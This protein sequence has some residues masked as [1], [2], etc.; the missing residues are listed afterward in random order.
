M[1]NSREKIKNILLTTILTVLLFACLCGCS[2]STGGLLNTDSD[3]ILPESGSA[4]IYCTDTANSGIFHEVYSFISESDEQRLV[5]LINMLDKSPETTAYKKAKPSE[6][7]IEFY[8]IGQDG[9]LII[10]FSP[11]YYNMDSL[12]EI[13][14]RAAVVKTL[15]QLE[16]YTYIEFYVGGQPIQI[17]GVP[18]GM[19]TVDDFVDKT[20]IY[21][22]FV[23][24]VRLNIY[25]TDRRGELL[26]DSD[27][28]V[29]TDGSKTMEQL[30]LEQLIAGPS[31][32]QSGMYP[33]V[34]PETAVN[35]VHS[36]GG[37]CYVDFSREFVEKLENVS[38]DVAVY[39]VVNS[40]CEIPGITRVRI[41]ING[42]DRRSIGNI[43]FTEYLTLRP[44]LIYSEKAGDGD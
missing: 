23:Q 28:M 31:D 44:E 17:N 3:E 38:A 42:D 22:D 27:M 2:D 35:R 4:Y 10:Y 13:I 11:E 29:E 8:D 20:A 1:N 16:R 39:S 37:V 15:C 12:Q 32:R 26:Q 6:V 41:S 19:M 25:F 21:T 43:T 24:K 5:E 14:C 36:S 34:N 40:L 30:V 7:R 33:V 18:L 9:Q